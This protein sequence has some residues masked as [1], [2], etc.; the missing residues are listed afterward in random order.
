MSADLDKIQLGGRSVDSSNFGALN[1]SD[2]ADA[3][4][5]AIS[6]VRQAMYLPLETT[7]SG[8]V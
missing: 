7:T 3:I 8:Q 1:S 5:A 4:D 6:L 2:P